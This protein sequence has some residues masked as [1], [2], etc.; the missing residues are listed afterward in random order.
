MKLLVFSCAHFKH[1]APA[2]RKDGYGKQILAKVKWIMDNARELGAYP[3]CLGDLFD[4]KSGTTLR[5]T[6]DMME[7]IKGSQGSVLYML[8]GNH[9]IQGYNQD[10][11]TQPIGILMQAGYVR[12]VDELN[13][14]R[15]VCITA[16][17]YHAD[18]E[19]P[20]TYHGYDKSFH[21][22]MTHGMLVNKPCPWDATLVNDAFVAGVNADL[23]LNGHNHDPFI[24]GKV[25]N[26]GS[27]ARVA[28][29]GNYLN[30]QPQCWLIDTETRKVTSIPI[31]CESD[32]WIEKDEDKAPVDFGSFEK[33]MNDAGQVRDKISILDELLKG[34]SAL[35]ANRV[36]ELLE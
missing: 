11:S 24:Y 2:G 19:K 26:V 22:H 32:V 27:I 9:D 10:I 4:K 35:T 17:H 5:E 12:L 20:E 36:K 28:R 1:D 33:S 8:L 16:E 6:Y 13:G 7:T 14:T 31:P 15:N 3:V 29:D 25:V 34:E 30:R 21:I 18:Y 23:L